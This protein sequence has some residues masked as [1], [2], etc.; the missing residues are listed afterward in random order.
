MSHTD[1]IMNPEVKN[2]EFNVG[3]KVEV[4]SNDD[5]FLG[6]YYQAT[7]LSG[8]EN[9]KYLVEYKNLLEDDEDNEDE[10]VDPLKESICPKELR[11]LPPHIRVPEYQH[12]QMVDAFANDGWWMGRIKMKVPGKRK[13]TWKYLVDFHTTDEEGWYPANR[14]RIHQEWNGEEWTIS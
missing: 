6:S 10:Y 1:H 5:G 13:G 9:G 7:I 11:P 8:L 4:A 2:V 14:V 12:N 3:D